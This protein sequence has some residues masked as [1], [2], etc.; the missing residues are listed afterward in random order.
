MRDMAR[1][2]RLRRPIT[3]ALASLVGVLCSTGAST[4][5]A[6]GF[7]VTGKLGGKFEM[8]TNPLLHKKGAQTLFGWTSTPQLILTGRTPDL[9]VDSDSFVN[10]GRFNLDEFSST[11][12]HNMSSLNYQGEKSYFRLD[13]GL[14]YDTTRTSEIGASGNNRAGVRHTG[15]HLAPEFGYDVTEDQE[16]VLSANYAASFYGS[17]PQYT[18]YQSAGVTPKY[19]YNFTMRD[20]GFVGIQAT[21]FNTLKGPTS[22]GDSAGPLVGWTHRFSDRFTT[23]A[24][25]GYHLTR[26]E[27][28]FQGTSWDSDYFYD[29]SLTYGVPGDPD[30]ASISV[31]R[32]LQPQ[33]SAQLV[34]QTAITVQEQHHFTPRFVGF[35]SATYNFQDYSES[36]DGLEKDYVEA[37]AALQYNVTQELVVGSSYRYRQQ[38]TIGDSGAAKG[39]T[40]MLTLTYS[41]YMSLLSW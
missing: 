30:V 26:S 19:Q 14:D 2:W 41:P 5:Y 29:F 22:K 7:T 33:S 11:D 8:D 18:N 24:D 17:N 34:T 10:D 20:T 35:L 36:D 25:V 38:T 13:G 15:F 32:A 6:D 27:D 39:H 23:S 28:K 21:H 3:L 9:T 1:L 4:V 12:F 31:Q 37:S 16:I 40:V